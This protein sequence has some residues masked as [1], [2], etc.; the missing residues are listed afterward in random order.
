MSNLLTLAEAERLAMLAEECGEVIQAIGKILRHGYASF[1][2]DAPSGP[3]NRD[4][5]MREIGDVKAIIERMEDAVDISRDT[6][7]KYTFEKHLKLSRFAHYQTW[8][9]R[10]GEKE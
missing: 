7:S 2:P 5:L 8:N 1:H 6:V 9:T 3:T 10:A 4:M